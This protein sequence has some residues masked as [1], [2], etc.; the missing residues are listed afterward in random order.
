MP[1][2][3]DLFFG[4]LGVGSGRELRCVTSNMDLLLWL[5]QEGIPQ[6]LK[7]I[8]FFGPLETQG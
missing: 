2:F 1:L 5:G 6:G 3:S 8:V 7:P 4:W